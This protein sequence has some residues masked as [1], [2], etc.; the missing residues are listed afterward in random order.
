[1]QTEATVF[2]GTCSDRL[3]G[4]CAC[5]SQPQRRVVRCEREREVKFTAPQDAV[6]VGRHVLAD[7]AVCRRPVQIVSFLCVVSGRVSTGSVIRDSAI[8]AVRV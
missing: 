3:L 1:M 6:D 5:T 2:R 8:A 4:E 7:R